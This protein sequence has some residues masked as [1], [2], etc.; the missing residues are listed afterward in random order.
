MS[1]AQEIS[2]V[3]AIIK[4]INGQPGC[5]AEKFHGGA[6]SGAGKPDIDAC[7]HGHTVKIEVKRVGFEPTKLQAA[8]LDK[9]RKAGAIAGCAH[10]L[11]ETKALVSEIMEAG[12]Q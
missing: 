5:Y 10:S 1:A 9:W 6:Y 2:I 3:K 7:M 12:K 8:T 11:A 4:W